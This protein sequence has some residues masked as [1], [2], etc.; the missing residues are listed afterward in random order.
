MG[1]Q[2]NC[3]IK[4]VFLSTHIKC[5]GWEMRK[6]C[7]FDLILYVPPTIFQLN[8]D[9]SSWV[10][11]VLSF[12]SRTTT[13]WC[14]WGSNLLPPVSSQALYHWV[15]ALPPPPPPPPPPKKNKKNCYTLLTKYLIQS[16]VVWTSPS[17]SFLGRA[18]QWPCT[19][20][21]HTK[22][23]TVW[24]SVSVQ[25]V[26]IGEEVSTG[27]MYERSNS[28]VSTERQSAVGVRYRWRQRRK[29]QR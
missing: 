7:L 17:H 3:L 29:K 4:T 28:C 19:R 1:V 12:C 23:W 6:N 16:T 15:T 10:E 5:F 9:G 2:K 20:Y 11:P 21:Q 25:C 27:A 14:R 18:E 13:K 24:Q 8:R 22:H 26:C